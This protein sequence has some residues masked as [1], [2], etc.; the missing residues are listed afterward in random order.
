MVILNILRVLVYLIF[1]NTDENQA[2]FLPRKTR[3]AIIMTPMP[4]SVYVTHSGRVTE[5]S[6]QDDRLLLV[7]VLHLA[8]IGKFALPF[9][10]GGLRGV[11][12]LDIGIA[13]LCRYPCRV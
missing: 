1:I 8:S 6:T 2:R 10:K 5:E 4:T 9:R 13:L 12:V 7:R 11:A 3:K